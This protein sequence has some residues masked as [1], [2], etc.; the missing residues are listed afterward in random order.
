MKRKTTIGLQ[1]LNE[2][3]ARRRRGFSRDS[4][5]RHHVCL[6]E[7]CTCLSEQRTRVTVLVRISAIKTFS[8]GTRAVQITTCTIN[9]ATRVSITN[10]NTR[11]DCVFTRWERHTTGRRHNI[12]APLPSRRKGTIRYCPSHDGHP[13]RS[14]RAV[15]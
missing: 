11:N 2:S 13:I 12:V 10:V 7:Q 8:T 5:T 1:Q 6:Y 4:R 15:Y 14:K 3:N 9:H